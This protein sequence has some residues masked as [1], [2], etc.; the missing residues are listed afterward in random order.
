MATD[1][2][3]DTDKLVK[4]GELTEI[5]DFG[6]GKELW[7][8]YTVEQRNH[9]LEDHVEEIKEDL[10]EYTLKDLRDMDYNRLP[11]RTRHAIDRHQFSMQYI[12]GG[13][14]APNQIVITED[15]GTRWFQSYGS[16]IAK[17]TPDGKVYLDEK[18]WDYSKTTGKYRNQFLGEDKKQTERKILSGEYTLTNLNTKEQGGPIEA[19]GGSIENKKWEI[20]NNGES[21]WNA[22]VDINMEGEHEPN[23]SIEHLIKYNG[24]YYLVQVSWD[25][26][27]IGWVS[28]INPNHIDEDD[29]LFKIIKDYES[30]MSGGG[31]IKR[32]FDILNKKISFNDLFK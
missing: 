14:L 13:I 22:P 3:S 25:E 10:F 12:K 5:Y 16:M 21:L 15:D 24:K 11:Y 26:S 19:K 29:Y 23:A 32:F 7:D 9:F 18:Y 6:T 17:I 1:K 4:G 20:W 30:T 31:E 2:K 8:R 27:E 28:E